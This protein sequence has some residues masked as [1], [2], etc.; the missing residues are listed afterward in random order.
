MLCTATL[1]VTFLLSPPIE[2]DVT[3]FGAAGNGVVDDTEA[4]QKALNRCGETGGVVKVPG[5]RYV[6]KGAL[7]VPEA[8]TLEG[9]SRAPGRT[10]YTEKLLEK[11]KGSIL[12]T[13]QGRLQENGTPFITLNRGSTAKGLI[14]YYPEQSASNI[15]AYPWCIRGI[16]DNCAVIDVLAINPYQGIDFGTYPAGRH[17]INGF[18]AQALKTGVFVDK[19]FDVGRIENVHLWPFWTDNPQ[20]VEWTKKNGTGFVIARTDWEYMSN[21]FA[22]F[23]SVGYHFVALNDGPGNA[24]LTQCGSDIGP[25]AVKVEAVQEHAGVSFS[26][27]QFMA[28]IEIDTTNKGPVKF[29]SCGFWGVEKV[30]NEHARLNGK[31]HT[32]FTACHFTG[33]RQRDNGA[34]AIRITAGGLTVNGCE[35]ADRVEPANHIEIEKNVEAAVIFANRFRAPMSINNKSLGPVSITGNVTDTIKGGKR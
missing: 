28:T 10:I 11:E 2:Y 20:V 33:W 7:N 29:T 5:G 35:F 30:T 19:C 25:L 1:L 24:V 4:F 16:G 22:I 17:K 27:S 6:I 15:V 31:G 8:V 18:Y 32:T 14:I 21:C 23:Y 34:Y 12:L 9:M 26:N 3:D 13:T